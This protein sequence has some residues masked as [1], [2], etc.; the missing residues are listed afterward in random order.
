MVAQQLKTTPASLPFR[1]GMRN[2]YDEGDVARMID[3]LVAAVSAAFPP[4]QPLNVVGIRTRGEVLAARIAAAL[5]ARGHH[6]LG[7]GVLDVTLY[8]DDIAAIGPRRMV[9]P[10]ELEIDLDDK[11]LLLV[12]DVLF[13]GRSVRAAMNLLLDFGRPAVIRLAVMVDRGGREL[14]IQPDFAALTLANVPIE[15]RVNVRLKEVDVVDQIV[16]EPRT[17]VA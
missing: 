10:T 12:D 17:E 11:P 2:Y 13:T 14:P 15:H 5:V 8:R 16:V 1:P 9:Q 4:D 3:G 6:Q 7:R